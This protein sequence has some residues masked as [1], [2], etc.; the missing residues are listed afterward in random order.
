VPIF[1]TDY[2]TSDGTCVRDFIHIYDLATAHLAALQALDS[3]HRQIYNL[4]NGAGFSVREVIAAASRV[5]GREIAFTESPRRPGDPPVLV[6][7]SGKIRRE[8][9]WMPKYTSLE[10]IVQTAWTW[11]VAN[12]NGYAE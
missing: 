9:A 1:G 2:P 12:P 5:V 7:D 6:A 4:G 3:S 11:H 10:E 8:L